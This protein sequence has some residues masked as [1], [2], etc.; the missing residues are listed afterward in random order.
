M[1]YGLTEEQKMIRDLAAKIANERVLPARAELD[2]NGEFPWE[3]MNCCAE[4]GLFGI[5]IP[6]EYG[7]F[8]AGAFESI[9]AIEELSKA[10]IGVSVSYAASGLGSYSILLFGTEEQKKKYLPD[11]AAGKKL[12]AFGLT[13]ANAGSDA[14]GIQTTAVLDG[15]EY[16]INGTKQWI[17]NGGEA[18]TY[19]VVAMTNKAKG[20]RGASTFIIE[21]GT[22]GF[23]FGKKENKMGIRTSATRELVFENCRIPKENILGKEGMGF[24][25][26]MKTLDMSRP[27]IGVQGVGLAQGALDLAVQ[28]ARERVQFGKPIIANQA[29]QHMLA[30]MAMQTEAARALVYAT[31][32]FMDADSGSYS[33]ESAMSK[34]FAADVAMKVTTDAVQILGGYGYMKEYPAEKMMRDAKILQI[35]EGTNQIQRNVIAQC[36]VKEAASKK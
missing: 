28:Y 27:G 7:G 23:S 35:Y 19:T 5:Y 12:A 34:C 10:C 25:I 14:G 18:E 24:L 29:V 17:T 33:K 21:K 11:I 1:D 26:A 9:L 15:N 32:R 16:V 8:G 13:E 20:A 2:E 31:T 22:P 36:L 3:I 6:E 4:A 30:D